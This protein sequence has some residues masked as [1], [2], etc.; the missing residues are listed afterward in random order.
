MS[1]E[2]IKEPWEKERELEMSR[3]LWK[4]FEKI[5]EY[6]EEKRQWRSFV[7]NM[8]WWGVLALAGIIIFVLTLDK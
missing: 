3:E 1:L 7:F 2:E 5:H 4:N 8:I 6:Q